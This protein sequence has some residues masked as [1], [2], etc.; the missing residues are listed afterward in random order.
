MLTV[1]TNGSVD[2]YIAIAREC[3]NGDKNMDIF[4]KYGYLEL[5]I[6][7]TELSSCCELK[8]KR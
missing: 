6:L 5:I 7:N 1:V 8:D 3:F 2:N 4:L